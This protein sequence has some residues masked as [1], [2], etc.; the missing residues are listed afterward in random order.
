MERVEYE[1]MNEMCATVTDLVK[2]HG[3][4]R[5][6][7]AARARVSSER[8]VRNRQDPQRGALECAGSGR[9][10]QNG[11]ALLGGLESVES[12]PPA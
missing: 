6:L 1:Y 8:G 5:R 10:G 3:R 7:A 12:V 11:L 9:A 2:V 4:S